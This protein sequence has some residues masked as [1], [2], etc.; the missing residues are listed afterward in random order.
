[1]GQM[2][3]DPDTQSFIT[4][5]AGDGAKS[6]IQLNGAHVTSWVPAGYDEDRIFVS[7][8]SGFGPG[9]SVR[10]G[11]PVC[12][13]QFGNSGPLQQH[14]FARVSPWTVLHAEDGAER[15]V[16]V[17]RLI[18]NDH[19]RAMWPHPFSAELAVTV[20]GATLEL[21]LTVT[22]TG[23][24]PFS[25]TAALHPYFRVHDAHACRVEG[26]MGSVYVDGLEGGARGEETSDVLVIDG[27]I[28]RVYFDVGGS[29]RLREPERSLTLEQRGFPDAVVWNPGEAGVARRADFHTGDER[30]MLCVEAAVVGRPVTLKAGEIWEG[31]QRITA[32]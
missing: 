6:R 20:G 9:V 22:N 10:G 23:D 1:M 31:A 12:F 32:R 21:V 17:L 4:L 2:N 28:D 8:K 14:G 27:E 13:P 16:A 29:L 7:S 24:L 18:D 26:L 5:T 25:F 3:H 15:A 19:T 11:I 30:K